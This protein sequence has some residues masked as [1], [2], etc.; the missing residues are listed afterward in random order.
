[1]FAC[2]V[3]SLVPFP[4]AEEKPGL[5]PGYF[6]IP[7]SNGKVPECLTVYDARHNVYIDETRGSLGVRDA[8]DEVARSIVEDFRSSQLGVSDGIHP[9]LFWTVGAYSAMQIM[10]FTPQDSEEH[11]RA[12]AKEL[13]SENLAQK[14]WF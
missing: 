3:V 6:K 11:Q 10:K 5:I 14:R 8:A 13:A 2:T 1:K 4:I 9:G 12:I 7:A